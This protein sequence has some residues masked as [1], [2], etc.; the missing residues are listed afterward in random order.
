MS[1][2]SR[3][4]NVSDDAKQARHLSIMEV[5]ASLGVPASRFSFIIECSS[6]VLDTNSSVETN[7]QI[8]THEKGTEW[9]E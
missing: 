1:A 2:G 6:E 5:A 9:V 3:F 4:F 7:T 8:R